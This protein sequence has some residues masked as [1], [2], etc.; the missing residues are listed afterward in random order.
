MYFDLIL[1]KFCYHLE[2]SIWTVRGCL[3]VKMELK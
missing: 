1:K 3:K 2:K